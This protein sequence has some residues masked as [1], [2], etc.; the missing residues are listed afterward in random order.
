MNIKV[1]VKNILFEENNTTVY[2][3]DISEDSSIQDM[4]DI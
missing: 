2:E 4:L 3:I 1:I